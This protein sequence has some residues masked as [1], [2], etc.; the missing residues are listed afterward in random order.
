M[1]YVLGSTMGTSLFGFLV[2]RFGW[3]AGFYLLA[4]GV[5]AT[6][7]FCLLTHFGVKSMEC[8]KEEEEHALPMFEKLARTGT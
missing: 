7:V 3:E 2:D 4:S 5:V 1:S 8:K 6:I